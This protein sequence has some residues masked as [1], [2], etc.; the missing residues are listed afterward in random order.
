[1]FLFSVTFF[2]IECYLDVVCWIV[3]V[4]FLY[5]GVDLLRGLCLGVVGWFL[6]VHVVY[7]VVMGGI[8]FLVVGCR[9]GLLLLH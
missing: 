7:L 3:R 9:F 6:V 8:G 1:M 4:T 5:Q 2:L